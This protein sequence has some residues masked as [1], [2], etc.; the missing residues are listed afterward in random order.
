M[1]SYSCKLL[2]QLNED[3]GQIG[4]QKFRRCDVPMMQR[5]V[6]RSGPMRSL[7]L[8]SKV[9]V[10]NQKDLTWHHSPKVRPNPR[11][12][13][14]QLQPQLASCD[15]AQKLFLLPCPHPNSSIKRSDDKHPDFRDPKYQLGQREYCPDILHD[16]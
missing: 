1:R 5:A 6:V 14:R 3:K 8:V 7:K 9:Y 16:G 10:L 13:Q 4:F 11:Q 2:Q 12:H 15:T